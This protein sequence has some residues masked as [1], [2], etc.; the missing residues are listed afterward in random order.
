[1]LDFIHS[2]KS[3]EIFGGLKKNLTFLCCSL[4]ERYEE[5]K[6]KEEHEKKKNSFPKL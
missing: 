3:M 4:C 6:L 5:K 2:H 1:M